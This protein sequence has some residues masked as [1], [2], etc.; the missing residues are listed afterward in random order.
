MFWILI[1]ITILGFAIQAVLTSHIV[2]QI[3]TLSGSMYRSIALIFIMLPLLLFTD[4]ESISQI[5]QYQ[6]QL[7]PAALAWAFATWFSYSAVKKLPMGISASLKTIT[8]VIGS[9]VLGWIFFQEYFT[10]IAIA[11]IIIM[12]IWGIIISNSNTKFDHLDNDNLI[13]GILYSFIAWLLGSIT[14]FFMIN[15]SREL[16]PYVAGYFWEAQ[17][18]IALIIMVFV[19]KAFFNGKIEKISKKQF[20]NI[21][22]ASSLTLPATWAMAVA[23]TMWDFAIISVMLT[24]IIVVITI[25]WALFFKEKLNKPQYIGIAV[26]FI[27]VLWVRIFG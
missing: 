19:R 2:R 16:D 27:W 5:W 1:G 25:I 4:I 14:V 8:S 11:S 17:I 10:W 22:I 3:D 21:A 15:V 18:A 7:I 24:L 20:R 12:L 9:L 13:K 26:I 6:S 23:G